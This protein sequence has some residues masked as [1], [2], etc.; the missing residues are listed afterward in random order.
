MILLWACSVGQG[1]GVMTG[2]VADPFCE[3]D[4]PEYS[5]H[6]TFFSADVVE[7]RNMPEPMQRLTLRV[8]RGSYREGYSDGFVVFIR[9]AN[10]LARSFLGV[11]LPLSTGDDAP[12]RM[13]IYMNETCDSGFPQ[14]FWQVPLVLPAIQGTITFDAIYA[15]DLAPDNTE[16]TGHFEGALF[17]SEERPERMAMMDGSFSFFYQ[18]GRPAQ[19]FP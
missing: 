4:I 10:E 3:V 5:L 13:T 18:R 7:E 14:E 19:P 6:P 8:Q 16:I 9:D 17:Q 12:V 1:N 2:S 15:P 11:P